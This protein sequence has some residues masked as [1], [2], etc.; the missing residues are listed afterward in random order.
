VDK[1]EYPSVCP[2]CKKDHPLNLLRIQITSVV[3]CP[4]CH[5]KY[6]VPYSEVKALLKFQQDLEDLTT[7]PDK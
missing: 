4:N 7:L 3:E 6:F 2:F 5:K 1:N